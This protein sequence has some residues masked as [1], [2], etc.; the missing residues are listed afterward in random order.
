MLKI[1]KLRTMFWLV[2]VILGTMFSSTG[3]VGAA[4]GADSYTDVVLGTSNQKIGDI[5]IAE[6]V[7]NSWLKIY[8]K[9][10]G[11]TGSD[12]V[13]DLT[14]TEGVQ[15]AKTPTIT[16]TE[17][18]I[19]LDIANAYTT[20]AQEGGIG[21]GRLI[22]PIK[23]ESTIPSKITLSNCYITTDRSVPQGPIYVNVGGS[24]LSENYSTTLSLGTFPVRSVNT[25]QIAN[26]V[27]DLDGSTSN[28]AVFK[29]GASTVTLNGASV[30]CVAVS[31]ISDSRAYL[32]IRDSGTALGI[33]Q[34]NIIWDGTKNTVT[35]IKGNKVVQLTIGSK[36]ILVNGAAITMD[37]APE[38]G[39]G[40][41]TMLPA[42]FVAQAFGKTATWDATAQTVTIK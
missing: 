8:S 7:G 30:R 23:S 34:S 38:I 33:D 6:T 12:G 2:L 24:A 29:V 42:A 21:D 18:N 16:V 37:V 13:L 26:L 14:L 22:I 39:P 28:I 11:T 35:L 9:T 25:A 32:S 3:T 19:G 10:D 15:W 17:G 31:Y 41:R 20:S 40:D 5:V 27:T 4:T 36:V 1:R